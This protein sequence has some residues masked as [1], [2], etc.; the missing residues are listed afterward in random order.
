MNP[1]T[2]SSCC[3]SWPVSSSAGARAPSRRWPGSSAQSAAVRSSSSL[4]PSLADPLAGVDPAFRPILVLIALV[5]AVAIGESLGASVGRGRGAA[6][7][8][9][10]SSALPTGPPGPALGA[11]QAI[12]IV[13]LARRP[14]RRRA[15]CR[16]WPSR[17][18]RRPRSGRSRPSCRHRPSSRSAWAA[19]STRPG[20]RTCSSG[21]S[22]CPRRRS[23]MPSDPRA[24]AIAAAAE[25]STV[26]VSAATCGFQSVGTGFAVGSGIRRDERPR[27]GRCS[28][29]RDQGHRGRRPGPRR[30]AGPVR[31]GAGRRP[32]ARRPAA[33]DR[34]PRGP[35]KDPERGA[36]GAT[37]GYPGRSDAL[38]ILPAAVA[39]SYPATGRD[40]Y[41]TDH[42]R[43]KILELRAEIEPGDSGGPLVLAD[44]TV[45]G[46]VFA[47]AKADPDVGLRAGRDRGVR[48]R[49][50]P[51]SAGPRAVD[52]GD[53][54]R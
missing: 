43:R 35:R 53:C 44:G 20:C 38:T 23:T 7:R 4:L 26:K 42:V 32:S 47:E 22:H 34:P 25:A 2:R 18:P 11:A 24:R 39:S 21:S 33:C 16:A 14:A 52:T 36:L 15:R 6:P 17:Q 50:G 40:I 13:W 30:R 12:L 37:L 54:V 3:S 49:S 1:W 19:S 48:T 29:E 45:G 8:Q 9:R 27:G 46:V 31:P 5:G 28:R 10:A 41:G 51:R